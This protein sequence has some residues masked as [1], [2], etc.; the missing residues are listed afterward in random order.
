MALMDDIISQLQEMGLGVQSYS[1]I[2]N[3]TPSQIA[4]QLQSE[5]NIGAQDMP[6]SLFQGIPHNAS[7]GNKITLS[8][9]RKFV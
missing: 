9:L 4:G 2:G 7:L 8:E 1:D 6:S 5:Y 3:I